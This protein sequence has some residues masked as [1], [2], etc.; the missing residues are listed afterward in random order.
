MRTALRRI[1]RA[2]VTVLTLSAGAV[3][4]EDLIARGAYLA[5]VGNCE[6]CHTARGGPP[7]AGGKPILTPFG[8]FHT[9]NLTPDRDTGLGLWTASDF[10]RAMHEGVARHPRGLGRAVRLL[11][12]DHAGAAAQHAA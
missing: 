5:T 12:L 8:T 3:D 6:G 10:W 1:A 4:A 11:P 9:T 2:L 7:Y